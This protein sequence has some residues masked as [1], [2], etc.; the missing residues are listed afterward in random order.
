[1]GRRLAP[2][3]LARV[4]DRLL[5]AVAGAGLAGTMVLASAAE[6]AVFIDLKDTPLAQAAEF[7]GRITQHRIML[8]PGAAGRITMSTPRALTYDEVLVA[9]DAEL[10]RNGM[11]A[12]KRG[13]EMLIVADQP[14]PTTIATTPP[15]SAAPAPPAPAPPARA[16]EPIA[17][18]DSN[19]P[20]ARALVARLLQGGVA[21]RLATQDADPDAGYTVAI[22]VPAEAGA[23]AALARRLAELDLSALFD[24]PH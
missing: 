3:R 5:R 7:V 15:A 6:P 21:A 20:R 22:D 8:G 11:V 14:G 13:R 23:R 1:M 2:R 19:L 24:V 12:I 18:V 4:T 9:F 16:Y 10:K 17:Y